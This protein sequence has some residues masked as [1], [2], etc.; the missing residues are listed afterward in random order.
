MLVIKEAQIQAFIASNDAELCR[1]VSDATREAC[2]ERVKGYGDEKLD[3][4]AMNA[5]L[6]A[7]KRGLEKAEDISAFAAVMF[8]TSPRFDEQKE[9]DAV[10]QDIHYPPAERFYQL[11]E[12]VSDAAWAEAER[13]YDEALWFSENK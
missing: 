8:E 4:M 13:S 11:F 3:R 9:I 5:V 10:L 6:R 1:V 2:P 12:R 7:R